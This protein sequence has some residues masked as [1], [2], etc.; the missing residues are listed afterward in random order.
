MSLAHGRPDWSTPMLHAIEVDRRA[1]YRRGGRRVAKKFVARAV[2][3]FTARENT[4]ITG[5]V[6]YACGGT[7]VASISF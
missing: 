5:Q 7:S 2:I 4:F 1:R 6:L 3:F